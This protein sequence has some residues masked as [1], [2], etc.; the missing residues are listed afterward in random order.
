MVYLQFGLTFEIFYGFCIMLDIFS[1]SILFSRSISV[2]LTRNMEWIC[3]R[4]HWKKLSIFHQILDTVQIETVYCSK[5]FVNMN[6]KLTFLNC[7]SFC[8]FNGHI[9]RIAL[10]FSNGRPHLWQLL[11]VNWMFLLFPFAI[12]DF[13]WPIHVALVKLHHNWIEFIFLCFIF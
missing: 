9:I 6:V 13:G 5:Q 10:L 4:I 12:E 1:R 2:N 3:L 8:V 7:F 11:L